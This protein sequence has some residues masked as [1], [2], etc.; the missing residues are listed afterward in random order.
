MPGAGP[1]RSGGS[2]TA[3]AGRGRSGPFAGVEKCADDPLLE[4]GVGQE[5]LAPPVRVIGGQVDGAGER[6]GT[7]GGER[8]L[9]GGIPQPAEQ[10]LQGGGLASDG[11]DDLQ[12]LLR[13][14]GTLLHGPEDGAF[15]LAAAGRPIRIDTAQPALVGRAGL[16]KPPSTALLDGAEAQVGEALNA[17]AGRNVDVREEGPIAA[18]AAGRAEG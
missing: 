4:T 12:G 7:A 15:E 14:T 8:A 5:Q 16:G 11:G 6:C 2:A 13:G 3:A 17:F 9:C 1:P 10:G 18:K